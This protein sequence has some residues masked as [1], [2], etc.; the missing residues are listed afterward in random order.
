MSRSTKPTPSREPSTRDRFT[1]AVNALVDQ[2]KHDRTILAA[3]LCGSLSHD[4]VWEKSDVDLV[5]VT[6]DDRKGGLSDVALNA[7]GVNVHAFLMQ[8]GEFRRTVEGALHNSFIHS[9]LTKGKL[10]YTHDES[11]AELCAQLN[12]IGERDTKL[13]LLRA[14]TQVLPPFYKARKWFITRGDLEYTSLWILYAATA[15]ARIEV[16]GARLIADREVIPQAMKLNPAF[17]KIIYSDLLNEQKTAARVKGA[18]DAIDAYMA[19]RAPRLFQLVIDYLREIG[20]TRSAHELEEHFLRNFDVGGVT[21][22]C[23]YLSDQGLIG[24]ASSPVYL[25]K[26]SNVAVQELAFFALDSR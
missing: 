21:T 4:T 6:S 16:I 14:A 19:E 11:I 5:F 26:R 20:E 3:I 18:I 10:L 17:F 25:T 1:E 9:F 7:D 24:K 8:R 12:E 13:Q 15:L 23:E 22:A 2:V